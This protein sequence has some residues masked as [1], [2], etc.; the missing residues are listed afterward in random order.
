[1]TIQVAPG[2]KKVT[3]L[4]AAATEPPSPNAIVAAILIQMATEARAAYRAAGAAAAGRGALDA[5]SKPH[6]PPTIYKLP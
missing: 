5:L 4:A 6:P 3:E 2:G 1:M